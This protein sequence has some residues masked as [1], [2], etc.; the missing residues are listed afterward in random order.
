MHDSIIS[1]TFFY[2]PSD[3][4]Y[5]EKNP[6]HEKIKDKFLP[7]IME[8]SKNNN[9]PFVSSKLNTSFS[10]SEDLINNNTFLK[11]KEFIDEVIMKAINN[12]TDRHNSK[13]TF[14]IIYT[15]M[16]VHSV[17]WN[18]YKEGYF[19]EPHIHNGPPKFVNNR[20]YYPTFSVVYI[21]KDNN[22]RNNLL[23][24]KQPPIPFSV[25]G[26][27]INFDT[28]MVDEI[29]EGTVIVFPSGLT[30]MVKPISKPGRITI[31]LNIYT[32]ISGHQGA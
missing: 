32:D 27:N 16:F 6:Y 26:D 21:L 28:S 8:L 10:Y 9:N 29:Q 5:W 13:N 2:F 31:A 4:V 30:H 24:Q 25:S 7:R 17:W 23:F 22:E 14:P 18:Y 15:S 12:M 1:M 3:F 11:D 20:V 19:Q